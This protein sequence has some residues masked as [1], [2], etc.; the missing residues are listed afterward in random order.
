VKK[1]IKFILLVIVF[2]YIETGIA[3]QKKTRPKR[4]TKSVVKTPKQK[5]T[6]GRGKK[7]EADLPSQAKYTDILT[8][9]RV[10]FNKRTDPRGRGNQLEVSV[11]IYNNTN[12]PRDLYIFIIASNDDVVMQKSSFGVE[13]NLPER[14]DTRFLVAYPYSKENFEYKENNKTVLKKYPKNLRKGINLETGRPYKLKER[15]HIRSYHLSRYRKKYIFFNTVTFLIF[16]DEEKLLYRQI[17]TI[18]GV[19]K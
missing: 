10:Y 16:D 19:R 3:Q 11:E 18:D 17:F 15:L 13:M 8:V 9:K 5:A 2:S 4:G 7:S 1:F 12:F 14:V 6:K